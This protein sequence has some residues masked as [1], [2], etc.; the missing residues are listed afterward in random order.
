[1]GKPDERNRILHGHGRAVDVVR[2]H[3]ADALLTFQIVL[4]DVLHR[5][6]GALEMLD[7]HL[8]RIP[9][10]DT[11]VYDNERYHGDH[12]EHIGDSNPDS[13]HNTTRQL[14]YTKH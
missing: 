8:R 6:R 1:M 11:G 14:Y 9:V 12:N 10:L 7:L 4:G 5:D 2:P 3:V 13:F